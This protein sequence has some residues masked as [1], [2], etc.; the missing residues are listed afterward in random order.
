MNKA[1]DFLCERNL[2]NRNNF[3]RYYPFYKV[4]SNR[5]VIEIILQEMHAIILFLFL[6]NLNDNKIIERGIR[7]LEVKECKSMIAH[8]EFSSA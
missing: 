3:I 8:E 6:K 7:S 4:T 1:R 5:I 2:R